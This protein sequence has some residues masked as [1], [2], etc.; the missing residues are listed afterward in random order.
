M[1]GSSEQEPEPIDTPG[2]TATTI[3]QDCVRALRGSPPALPTKYLYDARGSR[4]FERITELPEYS[5]KRD[6]MAIFDRH[7]REFAHQIGTDAW[8]IELGSG[9]GSKTRMLLDALDAPAGYTPIEIS[10]QALD[11][12]VRSLRQKM[13][14]L[15]VVPI[16]A[17]F[18]Q[19]L[20]LSHADEH[21][22]VIFLP[23]STIGN[24]EHDA[25]R[26]LMRRLA[27]WVGPG[28]GM[29]IGVDLVKP[30]SELVPAY[31]DAQGVT[32][33]FNLNL[34]DRLNREAGADFDRRLWSH[35]ASWNPERSRMESHLVSSADQ[36]VNLG[37]HRFR[38]AKGDAVLTECS[39]KYTPETLATLA[40]P[41]VISRQ[42]CD[43]DHRF[44]VAYLECEQRNEHGIP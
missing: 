18:T 4:L 1:I 17:D 39:H 34:L 28:G 16:N 41:F 23:G 26:A 32:A 25:T 3:G 31:S 14:G 33:E 10:R 9:D 44:L 20:D 15:D 42:W 5:L 13:P 24:F 27:R 35:R 30:Q 37:G 8:L 22:R 6:E 12:S 7:I 19:D 43:P 2:Q 29:L 21:K 40:A 38:F 36:S 11:E